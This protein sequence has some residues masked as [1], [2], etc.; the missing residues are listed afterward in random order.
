MV[1]ALPGKR[2]RFVEEYLVDF[3]G[4]QAAIRAGYSVRTAYS[5]ASRLLNDV[6]VRAE[7]DRRRRDL[8]ERKELSQD[9]VLEEVRRLAFH[10]IQPGIH[11]ASQK[12]RALELLGRYLCMW[13][14]RGGHQN[15]MTHVQE[16][17]LVDRQSKHVKSTAGVD[18]IEGNGTA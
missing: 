5:Q 8:I 6:K 9:R 14:G 3:N 12:I 11:S 18:M 15:E 13:N 16:I 17:I 10:P 7:L 4:T 1:P 2:A